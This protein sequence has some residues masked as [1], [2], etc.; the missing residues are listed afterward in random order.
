MSLVQGAGRAAACVLAV[1]AVEVAAIVAAVALIYKHRRRIAGWG[2]S[3]KVR[4]HYIHRAIPQYSFTL[5][6]I[7]SLLIS[8]RK[9]L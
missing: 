9:R 7:P 6:L 1:G 4:I 3:L 5:I 8:Q 2:R